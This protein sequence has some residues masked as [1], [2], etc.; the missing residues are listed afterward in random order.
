MR[1]LSDGETII[2]EL[3]DQLLDGRCPCL[4][5]CGESFG[6]LG[7]LTRRTFP[8]LWFL[9]R[10]KPRSTANQGKDEQ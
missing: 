4:V 10:R 2:A 5:R 6:L 1:V 3:L 9:G 8:L 7:R